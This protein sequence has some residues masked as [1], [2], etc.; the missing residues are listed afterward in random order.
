VYPHMFQAWYKNFWDLMK[1]VDPGWEGSFRRFSKV[2]QAQPMADGKTPRLA[3]LTRPYSAAHLL[4]NLFSGVAPPADMFLFGY[5]SLDPAEDNVIAPIR[6]KLES[7]ELPDGNRAVTIKTGHEV[8]RVALGEL[9]QGEKSH[10]VTE[11]EL[12]ESPP[13]ASSQSAPPGGSP[14]PFTEL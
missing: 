8:T 4:E 7:Y 5:A 13:P 11:V 2:W 6:R 12:V 9:S 14:P 1:D 3:S 10:R